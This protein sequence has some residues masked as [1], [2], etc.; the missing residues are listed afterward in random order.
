M[1]VTMMYLEGE[2]SPLVDNCARKYS[3]YRFEHTA[4]LQGML[5]LLEERIKRSKG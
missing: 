5:V 1:G 3:H 2:Y 4:A